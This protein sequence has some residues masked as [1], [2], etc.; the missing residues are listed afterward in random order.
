MT[1]KAHITHA[2]VTVLAIVGAGL[3]AVLGPGGK[4]ADAAWAAPVLTLIKWGLSVLTAQDN[5]PPSGQVN[6]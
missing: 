5:P 1:K 2:V 6:P 4:L 3:V